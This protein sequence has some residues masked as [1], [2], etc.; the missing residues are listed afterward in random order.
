MEIAFSFDDN[1]VNV[2]EPLGSVTIT[3]GIERLCAQ[4][5]YLDSFF[6]AL[7][8]AYAEAG[9]GQ[10]S[11]EI[12]EEGEAITV[13]RIGKGL[14]ISWCQQNVHLASAKEFGHA[15]KKTC[16]VLLSSFCEGTSRNSVFDP[17]RAFVSEGRDPDV[18]HV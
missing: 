10:A 5:V 15:L 1:E 3:E 12:E 6:A 2:D 8:K 14:T 16:T 18:V 4:T 13:E 9:P 11:V 17:I 7:V